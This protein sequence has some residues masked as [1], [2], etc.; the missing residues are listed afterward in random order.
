M[1]P[2]DYMRRNMLATF[3][4]ESSNVEFTRQIY[5]ADNIAWSSDYPH[6]DSTWPRSREFLSE[7][8]KDVPEDGM[9]KIVGENV[10]NFYGLN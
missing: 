8:L 10:I 9:R 6:T 2:S 4:F 5:G 3:Q 1:L 7:A